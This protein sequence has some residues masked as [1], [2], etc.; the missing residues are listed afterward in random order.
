MTSQG[1]EYTMHALARS[2]VAMTRS[3]AGGARVSVEQGLIAALVG[4]VIVSVV[5]TLSGTAGAGASE[6]PA[7]LSAM[8]QE[9]Q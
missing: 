5:T 1:A 9:A 2:V 4:V 8:Q 3:R 7:P 6:T